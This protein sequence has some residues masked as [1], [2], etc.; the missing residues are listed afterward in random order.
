VVFMLIWGG[1]VLSI[2]AQARASLQ[3][4]AMRAARE[5]AAT[6]A[7]KRIPKDN[8]LYEYEEFTETYSLPRAK[9][10]M[11]VAKREGVILVGACYRVPVPLPKLGSDPSPIPVKI[12]PIWDIL[13]PDEFKPTLEQLAQNSVDAVDQTKGVVDQVTR[14]WNSVQ[15]LRPKPG[16]KVEFPDYNKDFITLEQFDVAVKTRCGS[17]NLVLSERAAFWS[18]HPKA[19]D[20]KGEDKAASLDLKLDPTAVTIAPD[21]N[22]NNLPQVTA[23]ATVV[24]ANSD[25]SIKVEYAS[26]ASDARGLKIAK[27]S[28]TEENAVFRWTWNVGANTTSGS[29]PV[30]VTCDNQE[31]V[32]VY[33]KVTGRDSN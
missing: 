5:L 1:T 17:R 2:A 4:T 20:N 25:C 31:P 26:G 3:M 28:R 10:K 32:T 29:W 16:P 7:T 11:L 22:P 33:L 9:V 30:T 13:V 14:L 21:T 18:Q 15:S 27:V 8:H 6:E 24:P 23:T 12:K 19:K